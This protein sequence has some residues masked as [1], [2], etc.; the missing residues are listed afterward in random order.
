M[1][2]RPWVKSGENYG[3]NDLRL[4]TWAYKWDVVSE[5]HS[6]VKFMYKEYTNEF[7]MLTTEQVSI[8]MNYVYLLSSSCVELLF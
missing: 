2:Y 3:D 1:T 5:A 4:P 8:C 6:A 7:D